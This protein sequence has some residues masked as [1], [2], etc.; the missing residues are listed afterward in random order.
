MM[1]LNTDGM[2]ASVQATI[3]LENEHWWLYA[4]HPSF[5][6]LYAR[7]H[8][9]NREHLQ[10]AMTQ[11]PEL[12]RTEYWEGELPRR[13]AAM[14]AG[15]AVHLVGFPKEGGDGE[16]GCLNSYWAIEH[17]DFRACTISFMV[18]HSLQGRGLMYAAAAPACRE[19]LSRYR[20]HRIMATHLPENLRS[21]KLLR[22]LGFAVEGY[23]R[24]FII[25][26]GQWRDNVLLSLLEDS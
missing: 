11:T 24:D 23:A 16:I 2:G 6:G 8:A 20:L 21:A 9:R 5:A 26:N 1:N 7:F 17:G 4:V 13:Q 3:W 15:Q 25:I 12:E 22:R 19:V 10:M 14:E 18:E